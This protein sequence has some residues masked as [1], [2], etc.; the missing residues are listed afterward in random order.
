MKEKQ[1]QIIFDPRKPIQGLFNQD[2][3]EQGAFWTLKA[4]VEL[5]VFSKTKE[6]NRENV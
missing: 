1:G 2:D 4:R 6:V 3:V 5:A